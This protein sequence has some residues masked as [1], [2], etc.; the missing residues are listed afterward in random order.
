MMMGKLSPA[1]ISNVLL[2]P[3]GH[4]Y[5]IHSHRENYSDETKYLRRSLA[6]YSLI[7]GTNRVVDLQRKY[8]GMVVSPKMFASAF[9]S[10]R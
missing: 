8:R 5:K 4:V 7:H 6:R 1:I 9:E 10:I 2:K 3:Q